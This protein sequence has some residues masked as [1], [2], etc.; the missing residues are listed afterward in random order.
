M[1]RLSDVIWT[2]YCFLLLFSPSS[3]MDA[4]CWALTCETKIF[5]S[6]IHFYRF[7]R[8]PL[9][10]TP[11]SLVFLPTDS[12]QADKPFAS[13]HDFLLKVNYQMHKSKLCPLKGILLSA[14]FRATPK[15]LPV[16]LGHWDGHI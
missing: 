5:T 8:T 3:V 7:I 12:D 11:L 14:V 13:T 9:S 15:W 10:Q 4:L 2:S 16:A 6:H 1:E